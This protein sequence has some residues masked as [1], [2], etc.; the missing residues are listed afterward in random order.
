M[1]HMQ[2]ISTTDALGHINSETT[3]SSQL[4]ASDG[5]HPPEFIG[6]ANSRSYKTTILGHWS[7]FAACLRHRSH[8][9][10][11][12]LDHACVSYDSGCAAEPRWLDGS[13]SL[14]G[15]IRKASQPFTQIYGQRSLCETRMSEVAQRRVMIGG[16]AC[17]EWRQIYK[18]MRLLCWA[19]N[20]RG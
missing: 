10:R 7:L 5:L 19:G 14:H 2:C 4:F 11:D 15:P 12:S 9:M 17:C 8:A 1:S 13:Q 20:L 16:P 3:D 6:T 18:P